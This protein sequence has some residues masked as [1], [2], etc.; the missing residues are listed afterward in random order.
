M[1][2]VSRVHELDMTVDEALK[3]IISMGVVSPKPHSPA[4]TPGSRVAAPALDHRN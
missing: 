2:P 3:Y 1:L 4:A